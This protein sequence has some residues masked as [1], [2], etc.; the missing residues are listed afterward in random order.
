MFVGHCVSPSDC[1]FVASHYFSFFVPFPFALWELLNIPGISAF[2]K[3]LQQI[4]LPGLSCLPLDLLVVLFNG[5]VASGLGFSSAEA[6]AHLLLQIQILT[7]VNWRSGPESRRGVS[8]T[9]PGFSA[10]LLGARSRL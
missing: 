5:P 3:D 10:P 6:R 4:I 8:P 7:G 9:A 2:C 1:L